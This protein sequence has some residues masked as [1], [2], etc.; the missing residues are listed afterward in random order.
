MINIEERKCQKLSGITSLFLSFNFNPEI[1][2]IIKTYDKYVYDKK[3]YTWELPVNALSYLLDNLTY[4]DDITLKLYKEDS[5]RIHYYPKLQYKTKPFQ[6]Q[7]E[8]IEYG[9]NHYSC[10]V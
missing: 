7:L 1:I 5:N 9:L 2:N 4:I 3:T 8:G 6:H 10:E